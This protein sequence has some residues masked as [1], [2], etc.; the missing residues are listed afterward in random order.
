MQDGYTRRNVPRNGVDAIVTRYRV[1][2]RCTD[3]DRLA[4]R[5]ANTRGAEGQ[6]GVAALV[7]KRRSA[8]GTRRRRRAALCSRY[9][10]RNEGGTSGKEDQSAYLLFPYDRY[11]AKLCLDNHRRTS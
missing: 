10:D 1:A 7:E 8:S 9:S 3:T 4:S 6:L 11:C 5:T 2:I